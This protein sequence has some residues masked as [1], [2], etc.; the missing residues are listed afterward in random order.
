MLGLLGLGLLYGWL[1][2]GKK[3]TAICGAVALLL[4]PVAFYVASVWVTDRES[5]RQSVLEAA[6]NVQSNQP[7]K[8]VELIGDER[9]RQQ[10]LALLRGLH[11]ERAVVTGEREIRID[12]ETFPPTAMAD[13]NVRVEVAN[14]GT[15]FRRLILD[16]E[17]IDGQWKVVSYEHL[18]PINGRDQFSNLKLPP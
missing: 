3:A 9:Y 16:F 15:A 13:I 5:I 18:D 6:A 11:F 10:A 14:R 8:A 12:N 17:M 7:D 2:T 4:I 1:Q